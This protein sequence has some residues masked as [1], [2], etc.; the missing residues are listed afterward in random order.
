MGFGRRIMCDINPHSTA[1]RKTP[2]LVH[3]RLR[4]R[5]LGCKFLPNRLA[6]TPFELHGGTR[7]LPGRG[8]Y[9][10]PGHDRYSCLR[11]GL[12]RR[13]KEGGTTGREQSTRP[14][15]DEVF[16]YCPII[17]GGVYDGGSSASTS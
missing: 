15:R 14:F 1:M 13:L 9:S 6:S 5:N 3:G 17:Q 7:R 8:Y 4:E 12:Y 16:F 11:I 10:M 2:M